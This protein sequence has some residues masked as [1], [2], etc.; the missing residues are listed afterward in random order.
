M[1]GSP[2]VAAR[3][4]AIYGPMDWTVIRRRQTSSSFASC[5]MRC[6]K[7]LS[8]LSMSWICATMYPS[9]SSHWRKTFVVTSE[10]HQIVSFRGPL[11]ATIPNSARCPRRAFSIYGSRALPDKKI[12][13]AV[14]HEHALLLF[15]LARHEAHAWSLNSFAA[16]LSIG[17]I[18][19]VGFDIGPH[20]ASRHQSYIV[21]E[22]G[23]LAARNEIR[24]RPRGRRGKTEYWRRS[25]RPC[26]ERVSF[27]EPS[28]HRRRRSELGTRISTYRVRSL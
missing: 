9:A 13:G 28:C 19:L 25:S 24:R 12:P 22:L 4:V 5:T 7:A 14:N 11:A 26:C 2:T 17:G 20:V 23:E 21:T 10:P 6:S 8:L 15:C 16:G 1:R 18:M 27:G 3:A